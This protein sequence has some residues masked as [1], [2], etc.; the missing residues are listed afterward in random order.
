M[1]ARGREEATSG[2]SILTAAEEREGGQV[3]SEGEER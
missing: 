1:R 3:R 2:D